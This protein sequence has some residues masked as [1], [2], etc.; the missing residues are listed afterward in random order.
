MAIEA[1]R[2]R[3]VPPCRHL[4]IDPREFSL[5]G[6]EDSL[7]RIGLRSYD[8]DGE[9]RPHRLALEEQH[10]LFHGGAR[11]PCI[12]LHERRLRRVRG[13]EAR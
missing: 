9:T 12:L 5:D 1:R 7:L 4:L 3:V 10:V 8:L 2:A 11:C 13:P 6:V